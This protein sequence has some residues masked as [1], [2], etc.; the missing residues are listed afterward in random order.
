MTKKP[1]IL[2][3]MSD[4]HAPGVLGCLGHPCVKTPHIDALAARGVT[5]TQAYCPYPMCTPARASYLTGLLTP[6][7]NVWELGSMLN[8]AIPTWA[9]ALRSAGYQTTIAGKMHFIGD[10]QLHGFERRISGEYH[11][12]QRP[13]AYD[14]W[15]K[16]ITDDYVMISSVQR[17]GPTD[18]PTRGELFDQSVYDS[19]MDELAYSSAQRK[20]TGKPWAMSVG[21]FLPHA[22]YNVSKPWWDLYEGV[23]IP[24]PETPPTGALFESHIPEQMQGSRKW[25]GLSTD[26]ATPQ[27]VKNARR[28]YYA[29]VTKIDHMVGQLVKRLQELGE[30]ENTIIL[31]TSD[32]GDNHGTHGMWSKLNFFQESVG[33]PFVLAGPLS[34]PGFQTQGTCHAPISLI[35]WLPTLLDLTGQSWPT[36]LPGKSILPLLKDPTQTWHD[37]PVISDYACGGTRVPIRMVRLGNF[38]ACFAPPHPPVLYNLQTDPNEW[39]D[40]GQDPAHQSVIQKLEAVA[41]QDG[42]N[43]QT[44]LAH[45]QQEKRVLDY[46]RSIEGGEKPVR[47]KAVS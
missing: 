4:Q 36:P 1:N 39:H 43:P 26:G 45:I 15:L 47:P 33:L 22:P 7:H 12:Y 6:Q 25:L 28:A 18:E 21:Y 23:D 29:M 19:A 5:F 27:Q 10:E 32:H 40:L 11:P 2:A 17:A 9:H 42:W 41:R 35:D 44:L 16:P 31:Y 46:L 20:A 14:P 24:L 34:D 8:A 30:L 38:K 3:I 37:R 13:F